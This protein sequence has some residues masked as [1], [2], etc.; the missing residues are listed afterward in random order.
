MKERGEGTEHCMMGMVQMLS[1][2]LC[3]DP[4]AHTPCTKWVWVLVDD[5]LCW[6][7]SIIDIGLHNKPMSK[8]RPINFFDREIKR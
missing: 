5:Q 3:E 7:Y 6:F 2:L 1:G 4:S 8:N